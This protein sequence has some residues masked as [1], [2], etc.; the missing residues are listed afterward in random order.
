ME[1]YTITILLKDATIEAVGPLKIEEIKSESG[2]SDT[3]CRLKNFCVKNKKGEIISPQ[4]TEAVVFSAEYSGPDYDLYYYSRNFTLHNN[5]VFYAETQD[6]NIRKWV[7]LKSLK[8]GEKISMDD[9]RNL[10]GL[11]AYPNLDSIIRLS[12]YIPIIIFCESEKNG[13][14]I[15]EAEQRLIELFEKVNVTTKWENN[16]LLIGL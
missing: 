11:D 3:L 5:E 2:P 13:R 7:N 12:S 15:T 9:V 10:K 14:K 4:L 8:S 6:S 16:S 1:D